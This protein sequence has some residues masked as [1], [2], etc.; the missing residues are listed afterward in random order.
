MDREQVYRWWQLFHYDGYPVEV[1]VI[2]GKL[3]FSGYY[4][5]IENLIADIE[6]H[7]RTADEQIYFT[8]NVVNDACYA[9]DQRE[10]LV[11]K[12]KVTT[13]DND[14]IERRFVLIDL[15]PKRLTGISASDFEVEK[16]HVKAAR[17]YEYLK[18]NGFNEPVVAKSGNGY[19]LLYPCKIYVSA[20]TDNVIRRFLLALSMLFSDEEV[21]VDEKVFNRS[22]ICKLYGTIAKKGANAQDRPHRMSAIIK[23]PDE[24]IPVSIDYF[25][26]IADQ[27][28]EDNP[29]PSR[30]NGW[31]RERFDIHDFLNRH[32]IAYREQ[33]VAGGKKFILEHCAFNPEH[34]GKDAV[35]FQRDNGALSYVCLHNSCSHYHWRDFRLLYE[36]DAYDKK[37]YHE[38]QSKRRYYEPIGQ[39]PPQPIGEQSDKGRKWLQMSDIKWVDVESLVSIPTGYYELDRKII[40]LM[41]GD[42]T[43]VSGMSGAGKTS[44]IDCI[45]LNAV[46]K[47]FKVAIWSGEL[48]DFRFRG[49]MM[50]IAAG[51]ND[52]VKKYGTDNY[53]YAPK[54][55]ADLISRWLDGKMFLYNNQYG[56]RW[57]QLFSDIKE[58]VE[59][60]SV[61]LIV[62]DNL[63][64][65]NLDSFDGDKYAKQTL[66]IN[67]LK[68]YA[69][70]LNIH[71]ILVCHPRKEMGFL[72][73]E[74][75][76]GTADLTNLCDNLF[77]IHR[78]G[79]DF[80]TR[81]TEF[82]GKK[83]AE[84]I[85]D[86][87]F[88]SMVEVCKNRALGIVDYLVGLYYEQESRRLKSTVAENIVYGWSD[89][90]PYIP[91][92]APEQPPVP[93]P[94]PDLPFDP[95]GEDEETPF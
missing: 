51:K 60:M 6:P 93:E 43:V 35:I 27:Y 20:E 19:H 72:R 33:S 58:A 29:A 22:R 54:Q 77:I 83:R 95:P 56:N 62:L 16:A 25:Q 2:S 44:W 81:A 15:D 84:E 55:V 37:D 47:G 46:Q 23:I 9:R 94:K 50:Q 18:Q 4:K 86:G 1:R 90:T 70:L 7:D 24:V 42:V 64:A 26:K 5:D 91:T 30:D 39:Q 28:P 13:S 82:F 40:G 10:R 8:L 17:V 68:E 32:G 59:K 71:I 3:N 11:A 79:K 52:V 67:D 57:S 85:M 36:P 65:L 14:I 75:I 53:Y 34:R 80:E 48:Q 92:P 21:D 31:G 38:F 73:K 89:G 74:S 69:K 78:V 45:C 76:S 61:Q 49:W 63:M 41:L 66:F 88:D 12:P 87:R